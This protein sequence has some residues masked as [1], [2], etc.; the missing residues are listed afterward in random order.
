[1]E[2]TGTISVRDGG[3]PVLDGVGVMPDRRAGG[4]SDGDL[5][6]RSPSDRSLSDGSG[7][8][9]AAGVTSGSAVRVGTPLGRFI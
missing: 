7:A 4:G 9:C 5:S 1:M 2:P 8:P 6:D 3:D